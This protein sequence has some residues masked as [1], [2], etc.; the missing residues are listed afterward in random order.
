[1]LENLSCLHEFWEK[2]KVSSNGSR[3]FLVGKNRMQG[4]IKFC[5]TCAKESFGFPVKKSY[6]FKMHSHLRLLS[7]QLV[8]RRDVGH[9]GLF[10]AYEG[11][12]KSYD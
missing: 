12:L 3:T 11:M 2:M 8:Q 5:D 9:A 10:P 1:M 7:T 4:A 6:F